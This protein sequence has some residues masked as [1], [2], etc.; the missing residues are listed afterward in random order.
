MGMK[1]VGPQPGPQLPE[2]GRIMGELEL[3]QSIVTGEGGEETN[4]EIR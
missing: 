3:G 2:N 4:A 1:V